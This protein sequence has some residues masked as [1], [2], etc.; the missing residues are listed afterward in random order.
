MFTSIST[1]RGIAAAALV[2]AAVA[3]TSQIPAGSAATRKPP[4]PSSFSTKIDNPWYP[5]KPGTVYR[6]RGREGKKHTTNVVRVTHR[7]KRIQGVP[8]VVVRDQVFTEGRLTEDTLD[9]FSQDSHGTVWYFGEATR[10]L[11]RHGHVT[12][13]EGSWKAGRDGAKAGIIMPAH[14]RVGYSARQEYYKGHAEDH[15]KVIRRH[16]SV[17]V[18]YGHF[19]KRALLTREHT[20]LEPGVVDHKYYVRGIGEVKEVTVKGP[21][22]VGRLVSVSHR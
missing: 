18:P 8:C 15:F 13:R 2:A 11:D 19:H 4:R 1:R 12:S 14:P 3:T 22:E 5:L 10:E 17:T 9:W 20:P 6:Y 16:A 7:R 21:R